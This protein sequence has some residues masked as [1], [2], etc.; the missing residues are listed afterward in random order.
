MNF[1]KKD[2]KFILRSVKG[3]K[4]LDI[5][6]AGQGNSQDSDSWV[7]G[8]LE[9]AA[10][11]TKGIDILP[12]DRKNVIQA[13]AEDF[14]LNEIFSVVTM[15]DVIEHL[16]NVGITLKNIKNH[17]ED[18]GSFIITTP[19]IMS[20][21]AVLDV[22]CFRGIC[23]NPTH[24]LGYNKKML[25]LILE[26]NGFEIK[27]MKYLGYP[28]FGNHKGIRKIFSALRMISTYPLLLIW[29]DFS[30]TLMVIVKPK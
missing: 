17:L 25:K 1:T 4:L 29:K 5:G 10:S 3:K 28:L 19:N 6:S 22:I 16:D 13:S 2:F 21:G 7:F 26:N 23:G 15:F 8:K 24:T 20:I 18:D 12:C 11:S 30:P 9:R 14:K 27:K